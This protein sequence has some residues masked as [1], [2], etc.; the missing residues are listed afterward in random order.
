LEGLTTRTRV[1]T[2]IT[3]RLS[4]QALMDVFQ[5]LD[6]H[7]WLG[8]SRV[9][10]A[11][12]A[13][14]DRDGH[15]TVWPM[16]ALYPQAHPRPPQ[17]SRPLT[18]AE[19]P[20]SATAPPPGW[21]AALRSLVQIDGHWLYRILRFGGS[22]RAL[23]GAGCFDRQHRSRLA[24]VLRQA[25]T[26]WGA[27]DPGGS[28]HGAVCLAWRPCLAPLGM[29]W[30]PMTTGHPW[31]H[32]AEG[33]CSSQRRRLDAYLTGCPQDETVYRQ[34]TPF[35]HAYPFW[36]PRAHKR[37]DAQWRIDYRAPEVRLGNTQG[38]GLEPA[39]LQRV[40]RLR[41]VTRPVRRQ[42]HMRLDTCGA[43]V[44]RELWGPTVEGLI[45]D[46]ML[47]MERAEHGLVTYPGGYDTRRRGITV[48]DGTP[49]HHYHR[50]QRVRSV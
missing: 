29:R 45:D 12:D 37:R 18:P 17:V 7:P 4:V 2:P 34:Q 39:R 36:G 21:C 46:E 49:R 6:N 16:V 42:G 28:A 22:S 15:P 25:M 9:K 43:H 5:R 10:M 38:R 44:A 8:P 35:V 32:R 31:Q 50:G 41:H 13:L 24:P 48:I 30:P 3:T 20:L 26:P 19:Q 14:G 23:V 47:R 27:P 33:G 40:F 11:W 1:D